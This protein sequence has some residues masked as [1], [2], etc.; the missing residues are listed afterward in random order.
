MMFE[1][2]CLRFIAPLDPNEG[3]RYTD[4]IR[5]EDRAYELENIYKLTTEQHDY[6]NST[7]DGNLSW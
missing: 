6:I 2:D 5:E 3:Q 7:A 4:P 1:R